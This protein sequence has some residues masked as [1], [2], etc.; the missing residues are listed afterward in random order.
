MVSNFSHKKLPKVFRNLRLINPD[1]KVV[2]C[3]KCVLSNQRPR[4]MFNEEAPVCLCTLWLALCKHTMLAG[5]KQ[6]ILR[7]TSPPSPKGIPTK[8]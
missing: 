8:R 6:V 4:T 5:A 7:N 1:K 2:Y 3:K